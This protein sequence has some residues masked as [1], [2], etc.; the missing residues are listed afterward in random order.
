MELVF[1]D[2]FLL[3]NPETNEISEPRLAVLWQHQIRKYLVSERL[4]WTLDSL[5][6][7]QDD[8]R[9]FLFWDVL[10]EVFNFFIEWEWTQIFFG[11]FR[12]VLLLV[13]LLDNRQFITNRLLLDFLAV[14]LL[15]E[16]ACAQISDLIYFWCLPDVGHTFFL[17]WVGNFVSLRVWKSSL[18]L[19]ACVRRLMLVFL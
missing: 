15:W 14:Q 4:P 2:H 3:K 12:A 17:P 1:R 5:K 8:F 7:L 18:I 10:L 11:F 13:A 6:R 19:E 9:K 16:A